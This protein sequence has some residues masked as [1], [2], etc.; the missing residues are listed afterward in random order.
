MNATAVALLRSTY[1]ILIISDSPNETAL[2]VDKVSYE[3]ILGSKRPVYMLFRQRGIMETDKCAFLSFDSI[4]QM[5][6]IFLEQPGLPVPIKVV[7]LTKNT[8]MQHDIARALQDVVWQRTNEMEA[9]HKESIRLNE[10]E[11]PRKELENGH[12]PLRVLFLT[13][14]FTSVLQHMSRDVS[15]AFKD[16]G[17]ET[18]TVC[19]SNAWSR[20]TDITIYR[21]AN[22]FKPHMIWMM[23]Y[24]RAALGG[25]N[26]FRN[27]YVCSWIQDDL[28]H[29]WQPQA[30]QSQSPFDFVFSMFPALSKKLSQFGYQKVYNFPVGVNDNIFSPG[31][32]KPEYKCDIAFPCNIGSA[33][34]ATDQNRLKRRIDPV[35]W[36]VEMGLD[37]KL[38]G[39]G[40]EMFPQLAEGRWM[41]PV[42]N[43]PD[44]ADVYRSAKYTLHANS[45]TNLH[46]RVFEAIGCMSMPLVYGLPHDATD[47]GMGTENL[48]LNTEGHMIRFMDKQDFANKVM[49][50]KKR[51]DQRAAHIYNAFRYSCTGDTALN[52]RPVNTYKARIHDL[53]EEAINWKKGKKVGH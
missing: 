21:V 16:L 14:A 6:T 51:D 23:D 20:K 30:V 8:T 9:L 18:K 48:I 11:P 12:A 7:N 53:L 35:I 28:P 1:P 2:A 25:P 13:S 19:E 27:T 36:A 46:Q 44:L 45:D 34:T 47:F 37:I 42:R 39:D 40:W 31:P 49:Y 33:A 50:F 22:E 10:E 15:E 24:T 52:A 17:H 43:G 4:E 41:G 29:L 3:P 5:K 38:W 32:V 26:A